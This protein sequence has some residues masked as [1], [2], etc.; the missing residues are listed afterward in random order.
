MPS[1]GIRN[2]IARIGS[3]L[4][5]YQEYFKRVLADG[6]TIYDRQSA[7]DL[8]N[9][10][11]A[12]N[13]LTTPLALPASSGKTS[14][15]YSLLP[16]T[17]AGDFAVSRAGTTA[18]RVNSSGY[19]ESVEANIPRIDFRDGVANLLVE[20]AATNTCQHP[21]TMNKERIDI[22]PSSEKS[23]ANLNDAYKIIE[24]ETT[25]EHRV[26]H[27]VPINTGTSYVFSFYIKKG[28]R[29]VVQTYGSSGVNG[30]N[31]RVNLN[32]GTITGGSGTV[33][34]VGNGW[35]RISSSAT[36]TATGGGYVWIV[37]HNG[38]TVNY[39]GDGTS[40]FHI[41]GLQFEVGTSAT[42]YIPTTTEAQTRNADVITVTPP[43][44]VTKITEFKA[45]N[46]TTE[47]T[48]IPAIYQINNGRFTKIIME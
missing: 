5:Q 38:S 47:I 12:N 20:P 31:I 23:P 37:L 25:G 35:W 26:F 33:L 27:G 3:E 40:G 14:K 39:A 48:T 8:Y 22:I 28:E 41:W 11:K 16:E 46:T 29:E 13:L 34:N 15:L 43:S 9:Y 4:N 42:S 44:G 6:G 2:N 18:T 21:P 10:L 7:I 32:T 19:I 1:I 45:D 17:G 36:A 30:I 24:T